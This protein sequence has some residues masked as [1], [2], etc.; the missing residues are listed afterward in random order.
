MAN[1]PK[2]ASPSDSDHVPSDHDRDKTAEGEDANLE[3]SQRGDSP[4][5]SPSY[6]FV[7]ISIAPIPPPTYSQPSSTAPLPPPI[8]T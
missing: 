3:G 4:P 7:L 5:R 2:E 1:K 8:F 6:T